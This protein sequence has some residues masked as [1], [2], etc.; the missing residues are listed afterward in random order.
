MFSAAR[1][2]DNEK[3]KKGVWEDEVDAAGGEVRIG[4]DSFVK[5]M[6]ADKSET[7]LHIATRRGDAELV[8]WL[9]THSMIFVLSFD[10]IDIILDLQ[11]RI[12]RSGTLT[13]S[14]LSIWLFKEAISGF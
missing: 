11:M 9:D 7:L 3:V 5:S 2:G 1:Q 6:P 10:F 13:D 12:R 4:C 8:E 14:Q